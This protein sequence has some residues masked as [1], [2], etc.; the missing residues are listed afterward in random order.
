MRCETSYQA[1]EGAP[2][3]ETKCA[4]A[5][6][7]RTL[8]SFHLRELAQMFVDARSRLRYVQPLLEGNQSVSFPSRDGVDRP[9]RRRAALVQTAPA[10]VSRE[11]LL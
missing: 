7:S 2:R 8:C 11:S 5:V 6:K 9:D 4:D 1:N 3:Y 10:E